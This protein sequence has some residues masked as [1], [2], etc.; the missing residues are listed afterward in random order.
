M[1][2]KPFNILNLFRTKYVAVAKMIPLSPKLE[3]LLSIPLKLVRVISMD[4]KVGLGYRVKLTVNFMLFVLRFNKNHGGPATVKWLKAVHVSLQKELGRDRVKTLRM[5]EPD[6][7]L[8]RLTNGLPRIIPP[9]DRMLIRKGDPRVIRFWSSLFNLYR[10]LKIPGVL[11]LQTI[12]SPYSGS[13][14]FLA[15]V[16][17][18]TADPKSF[19]DPFVKG[20][21]IDLAPKN[22]IVSRSASPSNKLSAQGVLTDIFDLFDQETSLGGAI[23]TYI[24]LT[25]SAKATHQFRRRLDQGLSLARRLKELDGKEILGNSGNRYIQWNSHRVKTSIRAHGANPNTHSQFATKVE[26]AGKIRLFALL[27]VVSQSVLSPLHDL[28]F[29]V[30][31]RIPNDGTFDQEASILRSMDKAQKASCAYSFDLT[32]ATD[33]LPVSL[34]AYVIEQMVGISGIGRAWQSLMT[35]RDFFFN[36]KV[37]EKLKVSPG[38]YRYAV[39]QPMGGLSS[40]PGLAITH[41]FIMQLAARNVYGPIGWY[42]NY[43]ILGDDLVIFD[44]L[45]A[46]EYLRIMTGLG[47]EINMTKSIVSHH[48]PVFEFAKRTCYAGNIVSG[49]SLAQLRA[50]W[51]VGARVGNAMQLLRNGF[52]HSRSALAAVISRNAISKLSQEDSGLGILALL[53]A[54]FQQG[55]LPLRTLAHAIIDP[56]IEDFDYQTETVGL[57]LE[58]SL[59]AVFSIVN[60]EDSG[61]PFSKEEE[62]DEIFDEYSSEMST[63]LLD[64]AMDKAR[65]LY[66]DQDVVVA[67]GAGQLYFAVYHETQGAKPLDLKDLPSEVRLLYIQIENFFVNEV[68]NLEFAKENPEALFEELETVLYKHA[69]FQNVTFAAALEYLNRAEALEFKMTLK[70]PV[71]P[72]KTVIETTPLLGILRHMMNW[73]KIKPRSLHALNFKCA[74]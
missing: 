39:G 67:Q 56:R 59:N 44:R 17:G 27:D 22:F 73:D 58:A 34:T 32:A 36:P 2:R 72:G 45:V 57:P 3:K 7:P 41:H 46:D 25:G 23:S 30:L 38:P 6:I 35:D 42:T 20:L 54:Y 50:G 4:K 65:R 31:R 60:E 51:S 15:N 69:K 70:E 66:E 55:R 49:V 64:K 21:K 11:K 48:R 37:A 71:A 53:G 13:T 26:A 68:L 61:Y 52:I 19:F 33:R 47:C 16:I 29:S 5:F 9:Y 10:I 63:T 18:I 12:T 24:G 43:E 40:W 14:E 62:R 28:M 1:K 8:P 74:Y